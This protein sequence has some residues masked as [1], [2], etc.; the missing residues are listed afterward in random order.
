VRLGVEEPSLEEPIVNRHVNEPRTRFGASVCLA[1]VSSALLACTPGVKQFETTPRHTCA[2]DA[3]RVRWSVVGSATLAA[4]PP[5]PGLTNGPVADSGEATIRPAVPTKLDLRVTRFLGHPTTRT[6]EV[7]VKAANDRAEFVT[8][9]LGDQDAAPGCSGGRLWAT[10]HV[11]RFAQTLTVVT[12]ASHA[13]DDRTYDVEHAGMHAAIGPNQ[14]SSAFAGVPI[15]G[16]WKLSVPLNPGQ[17]CDDPA[18]PNT[19]VVDVF[20]QCQGAP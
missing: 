13:G 1:A 6:Q 19:V 15:D 20:T 3:V 16:D 9:S 11:K 17:Q 12:V 5:A 10:A 2:G 4:T 8:A 18:I 7:E 14:P